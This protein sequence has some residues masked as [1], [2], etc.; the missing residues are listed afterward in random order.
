MS[1]VT[2]VKVTEEDEDQRLDRWLRQ[3]SPSLV[4]SRIEKMCRK[5]ELRIDGRRVKASTRLEIGQNIRIPPL[6]EIFPSPTIS[7]IFVRDS[8]IEMIQSAVIYKDEHV[9]ALNKPSGLSVQGGS[10]QKSHIDGL[11]EFLRYDHAENPRLVHRLDKETSGV[12]LLARTRSSATALTAS[13]RQQKIKKN[14]W[15]LVVGVP[16]PQAGEISFGLVKRQIESSDTDGRKMIA[17]RPEQVKHTPHAKYAYTRYE[18]I[19]HIYSLAA[20]ISLE[21]VT[22]RSHQLRAHM[23]EIRCPIIGDQKYGSLVQKNSFHD[24]DHSIK[25]IIASRKLHLHARS[26]CIEHPNTGHDLCLTADLPQHMAHSWRTLGW[27][28]DISVSELSHGVSQA[29]GL[30]RSLQR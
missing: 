15:A 27:E 6:Y 10:G 14:Y 21:P 30:S 26:I 4:Q 8:D 11:G 9:I 20:W 23:A 18:T 12:L 29:G 22:G 1:A 19:D 3:R 2:I 28:T 16:F 7:K 17:V 13:F 5:G 24:V 25:K